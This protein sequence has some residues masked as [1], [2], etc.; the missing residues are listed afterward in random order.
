MALGIPGKKKEGYLLIRGV[1]SPKNCFPLTED[2]L[3][4]CSMCYD[5]PCL[6]LPKHLSVL[7]ALFAD[8][9]K[10]FQLHL[11]VVTS[12]FLSFKKLRII[13]LS[14][15]KKDFGYNFLF[16][17]GYVMGCSNFIFQFGKLFNLKFSWC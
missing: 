3:F 7:E 6:T 13:K 8:W 2:L 11:S 17:V 16:F 9:D 12:L 5:L 4:W 10:N 15:N 1:V 14:P